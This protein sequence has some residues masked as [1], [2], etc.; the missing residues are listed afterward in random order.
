[1]DWFSSPYYGIL[2]RHRNDDEAR[3]FMQALMEKGVLP[4]K[5]DV[6]DLCCGNGRHSR[7]LAE[8][9]MN[10]TGIDIS[11]Q[12]IEEARTHSD[13][14]IDFRVADMRDLNLSKAFD[15]ILNLFTSFGY[16]DSRTDNL[17]VLNG[18]HGHLKPGGHFVLDYFNAGKVKA[19]L[20]HRGGAMCGDVQIRFHKYEDVGM[21]IKDIEVKDGETIHHF[22]EKVQLIEEPEF[23]K[24][25]NEVGFEVLHI[26]GN[27]SLEPF[28]PIESD[29]LILIA[30]RK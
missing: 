19:A 8:L 20:P 2:Y 9:G 4:N 3:G 25:L 13:S 21:V 28:Q 10:V 17:R 26:F 16:F 18:I 23:I 27:Y 15:V 22:R 5:S 11:E 7:F 14:T 12:K 1:M 24:L 30:L 6:L 29:R